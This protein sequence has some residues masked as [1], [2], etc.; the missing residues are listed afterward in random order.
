MKAKLTSFLILTCFYSVLLAQ[1]ESYQS[2]KLEKIWEVTGLSVPESVLPIPEEGILYV[3]NIGMNNPTEK[4]GKG[5][6]SILTLNGEIK[7][8]KWSVGL[9]SPKGMA[10]YGGN[11]YV[12]E[13]D[14]IAEIDLKT[15]KKTNQYPVEGAL[16]LNDI[17]SAQDGS[18]YISDSRTGTIF[19]LKDGIVSVLIQS[20][21]FPGPNGVVFK[22]EKLLLGTGE[23]IV[24]IDP[25]TK[26]VKDYM[27]N[28]GGVDGLAVVDQSTVI[29][30]DWPGKVYIMKKGEEKELLLDTS[31]SET[32]KTADFGYIADKKLV[33][34]PTF[35][36]NSVVC[37][38][39]I[40]D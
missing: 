20:D 3:S 5:F 31:S 26:E 16:F 39:L 28:T 8:L 19:K 4:E 22:N 18:L 36:A 21:D 6:I 38:K 24:K 25:A 2:E 13:V 23:K 1:V 15:G 27:I 11:L 34:I 37:Y 35:F 12:S 17:A 30:S 40:L 14:R 9:N 10:I 33:Y 7:N 32:A 29:F